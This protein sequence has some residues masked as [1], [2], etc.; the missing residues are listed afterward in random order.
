MAGRSTQRAL[1][2]GGRT[3]SH[4][5]LLDTWRCGR[6]PTGHGVPR[7]RE[8]FGAR[9]YSTGRSL[10][11]PAEEALHSGPASAI[12]RYPVVEPRARGCWWLTP[13]ASHRPEAAPRPAPPDWWA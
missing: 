3:Q 2:Q 4:A 7:S 11:A 12:T 5:R 8:M 1:R 13:P 9:D 10:G 6:A